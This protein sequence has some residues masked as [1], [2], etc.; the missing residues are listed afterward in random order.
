MPETKATVFSKA[1]FRAGLDRLIEK[2]AAQ[3]LPVR[4]ALL[5]QP[6]SFLER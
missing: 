4:S 2:A 1:N 6:S 5:H 3:L